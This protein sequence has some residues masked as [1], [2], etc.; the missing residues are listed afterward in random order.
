VKASY[1][2]NTSSLQY[3]DPSITSSCTPTFSS[4]N[5]RTLLSGIADLWMHSSCTAYCSISLLLG[6]TGKYRRHSIRLPHFSDTAAAAAGDE[7]GADEVG[8]KESECYHKIWSLRGE[9]AT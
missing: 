7:M 5:T 6:R 9:S 3:S 4:Y 1:S 2:S 8:T